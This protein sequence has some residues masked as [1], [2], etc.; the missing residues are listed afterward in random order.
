M[1]QNTVKYGNEI[2][3]NA[4]KRYFEMNYSA[5]DDNPEGC[6]SSS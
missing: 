2:W 3:N 5:V 1:A 6:T 4:D